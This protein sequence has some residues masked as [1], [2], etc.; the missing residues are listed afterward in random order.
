[1]AR[2]IAFT[3]LGFCALSVNGQRKLNALVESDSFN[4]TVESPSKKLFIYFEMNSFTKR[5]EQHVIAEIISHIDSTCSFLEV[6]EYNKD[7]HYFIVENRSQMAL[8]VGYETNGS[9]NYKENYITAI[10]SESINSISSN[11]E[12]FHLIA[13]N[14]WGKTE[15]WFNEGMAVYADNNWYGYNLHELA[16]YLIDSNRIISMDKMRRKLRKYDSMIS[17][18][19]LGSFAKYVDETYGRELTKSIWES[20]KKKIKKS[21]GT[22]LADLEQEWLKY[23]NTITYEGI[24][25]L[26]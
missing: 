7:I 1:L 21:F 12:L 18:P 11:H 26:N 2:I 16:K 3:L 10:Y 23:L 6:S 9:A 14:L 5:H 8:L 15:N 20:D 17:Y 25:Y 4:W 22:N 24:E 19:L 13:M